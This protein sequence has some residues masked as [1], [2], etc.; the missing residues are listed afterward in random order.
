M[1]QTHTHSHTITDTNHNTRLMVS[2]KVI[3]GIWHISVGFTRSKKTLMNDFSANKK[4]SH[5]NKSEIDWFVASALEN[6]KFSHS[7][8]QNKCL[9]LLSLEML[10]FTPCNY[11][12]E[13]KEKKVPIHWN[14]FY[15]LRLHCWTMNE[16]VASSIQ[17]KSNQFIHKWIE[18]DCRPLTEK[19]SHKMCL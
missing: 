13:N 6:W 12:H 19:R 18:H 10:E 14:T 4:I 16:K 5:S 11:E 9:T 3:A 1:R 7:T 2:V 8:Q 15:I 17:I